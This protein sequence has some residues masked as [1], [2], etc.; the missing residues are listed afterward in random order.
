MLIYSF[1]VVNFAAESFIN[2]AKPFWADFLSKFQI[3]GTRGERWIPKLLKKIAASELPPK[4]GGSNK[5][6]KPLGLTENMQTGKLHFTCGE[7][8]APSRAK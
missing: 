5:D 2:V 7:T 4:Y 6:W 3:Y 8:P 1:L